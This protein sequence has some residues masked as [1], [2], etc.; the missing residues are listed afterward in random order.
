[1]NEP[2]YKAGDQVVI[3]IVID[4]VEAALVD[5]YPTGEWIAIT[6]RH[7]RIPEKTLQEMERRNDD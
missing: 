1:M 4:H 5:G 3:V 2:T 7:W 6:D